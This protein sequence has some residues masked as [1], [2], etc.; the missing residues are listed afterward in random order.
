MATEQPAR[1]GLA[2][3][4]AVALIAVVG[5]AL[6]RSGSEERALPPQPAAA[7]A[8][9]TIPGVVPPAARK[10]PPPLP[11]SPP[12]RVRIPSIGVNAPLIT[13]A[14]D[15]DGWVGSPPPA[16]KN[17][18]GWFRNSPTP[19]AAGTSVIDGHVDNLAGPA[20]FYGLGALKKGDRVEVTRR[21]GRT[22]VFDVYGVEAFA[23]DA[24][25]AKRV[26]GDTG[27]AELR[28]ITCG[29]GFTEK[30]GYDGNV[31]VFARMGAVR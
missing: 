25:P 27:A 10:V 11:A 12:V 2:A 17:L 3:P 8:V 1:K 9:E 7:A 26:Y 19:G 21:D 30:G 20:V 13:V 4:V 5:V 18:A 14:L 22:A 28:V 31:V 15:K 6:I 16:E 23:K 24:F 29:G